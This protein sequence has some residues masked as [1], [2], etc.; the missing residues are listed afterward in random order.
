MFRDTRPHYRRAR[1]RNDP[2]RKLRTARLGCLHAHADAPEA[3]SQKLLVDVAATTALAK[4]ACRNFPRQTLGESICPS[5]IAADD[6]EYE[7]R[8]TFLRQLL[9]I[10]PHKKIVVSVSR[11]DQAKGIDLAIETLSEMS[12][13]FHLVII[14]AGEKDQEKIFRQLAAVKTK[15]SVEFFQAETDL[16][17]TLLANERVQQD[18]DRK[19]YLLQD[20]VAE[21][22]QFY[23]A[24]EFEERPNITFVGA[25]SQQ[26]GLLVDLAYR[27]AD[28]FL[29]CSEAETF[30]LTVLEALGVHLIPIVGSEIPVFQELYG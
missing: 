7:K 1:A 30:G 25:V 9:Q 20:G 18:V 28:V 11:L 26:G 15:K 2:E 12:D 8:S 4:T 13:D 23:A 19:D 3:S 14:G 21:M 29:S 17:Q 16:L 5:G 10:P 27:G 24:Q 6:E 22:G